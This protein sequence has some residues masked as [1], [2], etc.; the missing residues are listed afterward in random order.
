VERG[1]IQV[2]RERH[3]HRE[4][5]L[6]RG[7]FSPR[8]S[9]SVRSRSREMSYALNSRPAVLS[10]FGRLRRRDACSSAKLYDVCDAGADD[11]LCRT[12]THGNIFD[13]AC[14]D[15]NPLALGRMV[16]PAR[17]EADI[18]GGHRVGPGLPRSMG[19]QRQSNPL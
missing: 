15:R 18:G 5:V 4:D 14:H 3:A 16:A 13:A 17:S 11:H 10:E 1:A 8:A 9:L 2:S 12:R 19:V 7:Y 6:C